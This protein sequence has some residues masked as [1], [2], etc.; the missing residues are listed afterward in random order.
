VIAAFKD[1]MK[2]KNEST[3]NRV[4]IVRAPAANIRSGPGIESQRILTIVQGEILPILDER[5]DNTGMKWYKVSLY[6]NRTGWIASQ[7]ATATTK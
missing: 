5:S 7:V 4:A 6:G 2:K 1:E 3:Q